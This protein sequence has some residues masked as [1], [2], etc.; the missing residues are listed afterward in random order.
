MELDPEDLANIAGGPRGPA[1]TWGLRSIMQSTDV[2]AWFGQDYDLRPWRI[3]G[4]LTHN[5]ALD[6]PFVAVPSCDDLAALLA[7]ESGPQHL[8]FPH[9]W[10]VVHRGLIELLAPFRGT[11]ITADTRSRPVEPGVEAIPLSPHSDTEQR[12]EFRVSEPRSAR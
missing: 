4:C 9:L 8:L 7:G 11:S 3:Q 2:G 1:L 5:H 10:R 6:H 12:D